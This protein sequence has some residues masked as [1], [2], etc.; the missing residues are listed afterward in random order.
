MLSRVR[1]FSSSQKYSAPKGVLRVSVDTGVNCHV[2]AGSDIKFLKNV[3][4]LAANIELDTAGD[5]PQIT[6]IGDLNICGLVLT[7]C[8]VNE[9]TTTSLLAPVRIA[10]QG[11]VAET[12][13]SGALKHRD[14]TSHLEREGDLFW[15]HEGSSD[16]SW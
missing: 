6:L 1:C 16:I 4:C 13:I 10:D 11:W 7:K 5:N 14:R 9:A 12:G 2:C 8:L 3:Q 15:I